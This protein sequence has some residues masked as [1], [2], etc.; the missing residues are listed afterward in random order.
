MLAVQNVSNNSQ[1]SVIPLKAILLTDI[2]YKKEKWIVIPKGT[3]IVVDTYNLIMFH[4][5]DHIHIEKH[6]YILFS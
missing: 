4:C 1:I 2:E 3:I 6:E 5:G